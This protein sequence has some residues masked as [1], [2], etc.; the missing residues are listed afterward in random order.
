MAVGEQLV[1]LTHHHAAIEVTLGESAH[2]PEQSFVNDR[3]AFD[4]FGHAAPNV[5]PRATGSVSTDA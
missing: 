4:L 3:S 5:R 2:T 1:D